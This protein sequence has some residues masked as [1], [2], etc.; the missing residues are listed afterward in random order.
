MIRPRWLKRV[1]T[2]ILLFTLLVIVSC[3]TGITRDTEQTTA[4]TQHAKKTDEK[5]TIV[6]GELVIKEESDYILIPV[7]LSKDKNQTRTNLLESSLSYERQDLFSNLIFYRKQ[8]GETHLL[9]NKPALLSS[10]DFLEKKEQG[11]PPTR[12]WLYKIIENDTNAD[13]KL[14]LEDATI[15][16]LSDLS[17]K[18]IQQITPNN[19]Q[20]ISW[21]VVQS[22]GAILAK[23]IK[24]SDNDQKFTERDETAFIQ[25]NLSK[26]AIGTEI[27][28]E[29]IKQQ[30]QSIN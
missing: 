15:G 13:K 4:I 7:R 3:K 12:Y 17:G 23:I 25:V 21:T 6:Y 26:P 10:F 22:M 16:Y 28:S 14:T 2:A 18:N 1:L 29:Q 8:D 9:L 11:K 24:D 5:P 27:I 30:L 19:T 20:L